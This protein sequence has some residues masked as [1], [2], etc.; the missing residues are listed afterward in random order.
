[1]RRPF[2]IAAIL[3]LAA[4]KPASN[5]T[6]NGVTIE[7]PPAVPVENDAADSDALANPAGEANALN[8][9]TPTISER[10]EAPIR[11][12]ASPAVARQ[13]G[14][15]KGGE[16]APQAAALPKTEV[17]KS[18]VAGAAQAP[19]AATPSASE[20]PQTSEAPALGPARPPLSDERIAGIIDRIGF[21]CGSVVSTSPVAAVDG[22]PAYKITCSSG[23]AYLGTNR[24]GHMRFR[25]WNP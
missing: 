5:D 11:S 6:E 20:E 14:H 3:L 1:M 17:A 25:K 7:L 18:A 19:A 10:D 12:G 16:E 8:V 13:E 21:T 15:P 24:G 22:I 4:C 23:S 2:F 9:M